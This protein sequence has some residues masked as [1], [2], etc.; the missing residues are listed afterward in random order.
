MGGVSVCSGF[1]QPSWEATSISIALMT[2]GHPSG[3]GCCHHTER[4]TKT[5]AERLAWCPVFPRLQVPVPCRCPSARLA[6]VG[7]GTGSMTADGWQES[8]A[9]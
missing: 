2:L 4:E 1:C 7:A 6:T 9:L 5:Q 8:Q 3:Q